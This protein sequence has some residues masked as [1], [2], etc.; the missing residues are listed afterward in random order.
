MQSRFIPNHCCQNVFNRFSVATADFCHL[1]SIKA[2]MSSMEACCAAKI[3][4]CFDSA[5]GILSNCFTNCTLGLGHISFYFALVHGSSISRYRLDT[6]DSRHSRCN[7]GM[8]E[9][10]HTNASILQTFGIGSSIGSTG[11]RPAYLLTNS[12]SAQN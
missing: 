3:A 8:V 12:G 6:V 7:S 11:R 2:S 10:D 5:G 1:D 4:R 9:L